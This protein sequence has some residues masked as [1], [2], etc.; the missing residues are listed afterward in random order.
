MRALTLD[1][2]GFVSGG[3]DEPMQEVVVTGKRG[4]S[5]AD[6]QAVLDWLNEGARHTPIS[7]SSGGIKNFFGNIYLDVPDGIYAEA[8]KNYD[9]NSSED[10]DMSMLEADL[11]FLAEMM[12]ADV[13][14]GNHGSGLSLLYF[15]GVRLGGW[16]TYEGDKQ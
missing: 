3:D 7:G 16:S 15:L 1:E 5:P 10:T 13:K 4:W 14:N 2:V 6:I 8:C 12:H 9:K 11:A